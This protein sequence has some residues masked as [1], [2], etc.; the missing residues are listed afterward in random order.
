MCSTCFNTQKSNK[1]IVDRT[2]L[3][4]KSEKL[5]NGMYISKRWAANFF[6]IWSIAAIIMPKHHELRQLCYPGYFEKNG[7][8]WYQQACEAMQNIKPTPDSEVE[9]EEEA[10]QEVVFH[11]LQAQRSLLLGDSDSCWNF[12]GQAIRKGVNAHMFKHEHCSSYKVSKRCRSQSALAQFIVHTDRWMCFNRRLPFGIASQ[13]IRLINGPT[14]TSE[15]RILRDLEAC[16]DY[17]LHY[18]K[19]CNDNP[20]TKYVVGQRLLDLIQADL[21]QSLAELN[22][23]KDLLSKRKD[24]PLNDLLPSS[25]DS[26]ARA[27]VVQL[28]A[29]YL[30]IQ[31]FF[32][33]DFMHD[34][35]APKAL[36]RRC[37]DTAD[38]LLRTIPVL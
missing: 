20:D 19:L 7:P 17:R 24:V 13:Y 6:L 29:S 18:S 12:I 23:P 38:S 36:Q 34:E 5:W 28:M 11:A 30:Y 8:L 16:H 4:Y 32:G 37:I 2:S 35:H 31:C 14:A 26:A 10:V 27:S 15:A 1:D 22:A 33:L 25:M 9:E 3:I 21:V